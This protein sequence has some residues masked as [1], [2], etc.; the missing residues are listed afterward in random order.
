MKRP[1]R[2]RIE[3]PKW[4]TYTAACII[5]MME[6]LKGGGSLSAYRASKSHG[7]EPAV[8]S[9]AW[10]LERFAERK[11]GVKHAIAVNSGTAALITALRSIGVKNSEVITSPYTFSA[12]A[13]AILEAGGTPRFA[14]VDPDTYVIQA[15][16]IGRMINRNTRAILPVH[17]FGYVQP[18]N[19]LLQFGLPIVEDACQ[20]V[21]V[22]RS[23]DRGGGGGKR[24]SGTFGAVGCY[25]FQ[26]GKQCPAGEG[27]MVV[28]N[29][30][31]L[32]E[33]IRF[34]MNHG[35]NFSMAWQ[36]Q[37]YR[38]TEMTCLLAYH[39]LLELDRRIRMRREYAGRFN[40]E[41]MDVKGF[42][43][44]ALD[45]SEA[46]S[47]YVYGF[48]QAVME[49]EYFKRLLARHGIPSGAGYIV[50]P[51]HQYPLFRKYVNRRLPVVEELSYHRLG[52][53]DF[54]RGDL[55]EETLSYVIRVFRDLLTA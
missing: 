24:Y 11:F 7:V 54:L 49:N 28:T 1:K 42:K 13:A 39:G 18:M 14:D 5:D 10:R 12:T 21:G 34:Y 9:W 30:S 41:M 6:L 4:P 51:L 23:G 44:Q 2:K 33:K 3:I 45:V 53:L 27:G 38:P 8:G 20:A 52:L 29:D 35:E 17:L 40:R 48:T 26:G 16:T 55:P 36:G 32:A 50:P 19:E 43:P 47:Y 37:N 46:S 22:C 31:S 15:E 25:S